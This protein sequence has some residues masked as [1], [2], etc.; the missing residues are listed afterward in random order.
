MFLLV[1]IILFVLA[2]IILVKSGAIVVKSLT[3]LSHIFGLKEFMMSFVLMSVATSIPELFVGLTAAWQGE[4]LLS[5]GNVFGASI[6]DLTLVAGIAAI[7][8]KGIRFHNKLA[9]KESVQAG[10]IA[11]LPLCLLL[12]KKL[13]RFDGVLLLLAVVFYLL[14][15]SYDRKSTTKIYHHHN[16][17]PK[18]KNIM[19]LIAG[20][21]L[22]LLSAKGIV[23]SATAIAVA[24][25]LP[26]IIIGLL[27]VALGTTLPELVFSTRSALTGHEEMV[28]GNIFGSIVIKATIV[29]GIVAIISPFSV[30]HQPAL[31]LAAIMFLL[32]VL[33]LLIF[34]R[35]KRAL[36]WQ[37]GLILL[38]LYLI[39]VVGEFIFFNQ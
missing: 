16:Q 25:D 35:T 12:D 22:L 30:S 13:T 36:S 27:V 21:V 19:Y 5:L 33:C 31:L 39:F 28:L 1:N 10:L 26:V 2:S 24:L 15:L 23:M 14:F 4:P 37:E 6:A 18:F 3:H 34:I 11:L 38:F 8:G 29:L 9:E 17:P 32:S 20:L 7:L